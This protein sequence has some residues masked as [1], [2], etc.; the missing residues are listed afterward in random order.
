M[1]VT[2]LGSKFFNSLQPFEDDYVK[3]TSFGYG[4]FCIEQA[5]YDGSYD[6]TKEINQVLMLFEKAIVNAQEKRLSEAKVVSFDYFSHLP[7]DKINEYMNS[8]YGSTQLF[9]A[10]SS[11][12]SLVTLPDGDRQNTLF[13]CSFKAW[14]AIGP[15]FFQFLGSSYGIQCI[16]KKTHL[17][18]R[19]L[20]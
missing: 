3:C 4:N 20:F 13:R 15:K 8:A 16:E 2:N 11:D 7:P 17:I 14:Q 19:S 18:C 10:T 12:E 9:A 6:A 5:V 1:S